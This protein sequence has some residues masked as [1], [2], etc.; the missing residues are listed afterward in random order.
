MAHALSGQDEE[1]FM[2]S[3]FLLQHS[4]EINDFEETKVIGIYL[5]RKKA[6][7]VIGKYKK[8]QGFKDYPDS[9]YIDEYE[10]DKDNWEEGFVRVI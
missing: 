5:S 8:L 2:T 3:V 1:F 6:E 7:Q 10:M 9:F 4:Y